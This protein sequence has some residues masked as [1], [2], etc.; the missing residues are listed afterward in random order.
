MPA[1]PYAFTGFGEVELEPSPN[2]QNQEEGP[3]VDWSKNETDCPV[4]GE[5]GL[6]LKAATGAEAAVTVIDL[7]S[8]SEPPAFEAVSV[9]VYVP[10]AA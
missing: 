7:D 4:T 2:V 8:E 3:P 6:K 9:T 5:A 10:A 1:A